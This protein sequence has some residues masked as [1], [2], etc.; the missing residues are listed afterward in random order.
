MSHDQDTRAAPVTR[1]AW[2]VLAA[3]VA[4]ATFRA[5]VKAST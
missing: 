4:T 1:G 2:L 3:V 5:T